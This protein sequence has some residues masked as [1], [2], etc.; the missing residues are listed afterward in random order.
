MFDASN[1]FWIEMLCASK[2]RDICLEVRTN[3]LG[4]WLNVLFGI[5]IVVAFLFLDETW[6]SYP[7]LSAIAY[8]HHYAHSLVSTYEAIL[9]IWASN[10]GRR[11]QSTIDN[12]QQLMLP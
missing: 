1:A 4:I 8:R 7:L 12:N 2:W 5:T 6:K 3:K 11:K 9:L 10:E